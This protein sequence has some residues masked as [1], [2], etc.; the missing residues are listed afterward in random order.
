MKAD[1]EKYGS[2]VQINIFG[3]EAK[4]RLGDIF[5]MVPSVI[6]A[7]RHVEEKE[8]SSGRGET[9]RDDEPKPK[10]EEVT[11]FA[12]F[13]N[14]LKNIVAK[15]G[16][17]LEANCA[18][19]NDVKYF[20]NVYFDAGKDLPWAVNNPWPASDKELVEEAKLDEWVNAIRESFTIE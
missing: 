3:E 19:F 9:P 20:T 4:S 11:I 8:S 15:I 18:R 14:V 5:S 7:R 16:P 13:H 10:Y 6:R 2:D 1:E 17:A 12:E